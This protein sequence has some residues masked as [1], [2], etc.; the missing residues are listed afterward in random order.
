MSP[1]DDRW[2]GG[3]SRIEWDADRHGRVPARRPINLRSRHKKPQVLIG[4]LVLVLGI[5]ALTRGLNFAS[6]RSDI[7]VGDFSASVQER[8]SVPQWV[9]IAA[10][11]GG[12][13]LVGAG[14]RVRKA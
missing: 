9:G 3:Y 10:I 14:Y 6:G 11:V 13:L 4:I 8:S 12:A 1:T 5:V 7:R 2:R